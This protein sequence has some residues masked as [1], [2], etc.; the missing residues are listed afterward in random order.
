[1]RAPAEF[2]APLGAILEADFA[3]EGVRVAHELIFDLRAFRA[4]GVKE[5]DVAKRLMDYGFH[6]RTVPFPVAGALTPG[7]LGS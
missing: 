1:M 7:R 6:A 5:M 3:R 2:G 4:G